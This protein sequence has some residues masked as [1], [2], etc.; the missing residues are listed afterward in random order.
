MQ[1]KISLDGM[2]LT[3][4]SPVDAP[5]RWGWVSAAPS[6]HLIV[7]RRGK[8]AEGLCGQGGRFFKWPAD[9][10]VVVPTTLKEVVF[11]A[12]QITRDSVDVRVRGMV[13]Y[14]IQ[15]PMRIHRLINFTYRQQ[16]E[17]KLARMIADM[18]RSTSK[19]LV[20]NM[21]LEE[22]FAAAKRRSPPPSARRWPRSPPRAGAWRS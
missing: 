16:G 15:D 3:S 4:N 7:Y 11:Q 10:Y 19:W 8:L 21:H 13:V 12:N 9:T 22:S 5:R 1:E 6:E 17:A 14:R 18:C 20:A 2:E